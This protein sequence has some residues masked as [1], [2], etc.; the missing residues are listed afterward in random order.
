MPAVWGYREDAIT[1]WAASKALWTVE[2]CFAI[3]CLSSEFESLFLALVSHVLSEGVR[4]ENRD[5]V[6]ARLRSATLANGDGPRRCRRLAAMGRGHKVHRQTRQEAAWNHPGSQQRF[7]RHQA[8]RQQ[9]QSIV[10]AKENHQRTED[11]RDGDPY[12]AETAAT[13]RLAANVSSTT[14]SA[15]AKYP[16]VDEARQSTTVGLAIGPRNLAFEI[17]SVP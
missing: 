10:V 1:D 2:R 4:R 15:P 9:H 6:L 7:S 11:R 13:E 16:R 12:P 8:V 5:T 17:V 14:G 3:L